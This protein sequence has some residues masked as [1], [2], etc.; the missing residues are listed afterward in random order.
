MDQLFRQQ[1]TNSDSER[2][3][4]L[5]YLAMMI[6][7]HRGSAGT[8][9]ENTLS[10]VQTALDAGAPWVEID[11]R[12]IADKLFVI[13]D[14]HVDRTTNGSGDI[15]AMSEAEI[16]QL[17]AGDGAGI[18]TL[19]SVIELIQAKAA[20][21]IELKDVESLGPVLS[22]VTATLM[23]KPAWAGR[24][25]ISTFEQEIH[26]AMA[27][28]LPPGCLLGVLLN[29]VSDDAVPYASSLGAYSL[30][31]SFAQLHE[32]IVSSAHQAGLKVFVYTVNESDH[33]DSCLAVGVDAIYTDFP[34]RSAAYLDAS[35]A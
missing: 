21:N 27:E 29:A 18:P 22:V 3:D 12:L 33:I 19:E 15:Y 23:N 6:I 34:A 35:S 20:L 25:M 24:L 4:R 10:S 26:R 11:V 14:R 7:G 16:L 28:R 1:T 17:D 5:K 31:L 9:P 13:H 2:N 32:D 30:N 8:V